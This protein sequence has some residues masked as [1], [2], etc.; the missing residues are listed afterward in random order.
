[1]YVSGDPIISQARNRGK[2][3]ALEVQG[4][5]LFQG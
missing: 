5:V 4:Y 2:A 3:I 1:M